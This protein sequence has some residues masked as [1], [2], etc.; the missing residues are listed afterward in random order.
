MIA[1][2]IY[3]LKRE[4][5][6]SD[7]FKGG[8]R[9]PWWAS[10]LSIYATLLSSITYMSIPAK[11]YATDWSYYPML[12]T[13]VVVTYPV[14][15]YYLPYF[16]KLNLT[17]AYEYLDQRFNYRVRFCASISF[18]SFMVARMALVLYM[19][20]LALATVSGMNIYITII[21]M[22]I[23]TL[24]YVTMG[25][26]EAVVWGDVIQGAILIGGVL[27]SA[28]YLIISTEGGF[29]QYISIGLAD[30]KFCL[31]EWSWDLTKPT[32]VVVIL[33]G[34]ANNLISLTSDQTVIQR[35][36]TTST[37][38]GAARSIILNSILSVF[39]SV[40]FYIIGTGLYTFYKTHPELY[41]STLSSTDAL[42]PYFMA[43]QMPVGVAGLV[44]A[45]IFSATMSTVSSNINSISASFTIDIYSHLYRK[46]SDK[47]RL[48]CARYT[49]IISGSLGVGLALLMATWDIKSLVDYFNSILGI[50]TSGLGALFFIGRFM[51]CID[52]RGALL[53]FFV[54]FIGVILISRYSTL[55]FLLYGAIGMI[56]SIATAFLY[57]LLAQKRIS[58]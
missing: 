8:G 27:F 19:P 14:I 13:I 40:F 39:V 38:Q 36:M 12:V 23:I 34:I 52:S 49:S 10:G 57:D 55:S 41:P 51:P 24:F 50:L 54:S 2:G 21:I 29:D 18:I 11:A 35:Y 56:L 37:Q 45:A 16:R 17:S 3:F 43:Y 30:N 58:I 47:K 6:S 7:F 5:S 20:A 1:V 46:L 42:L 32:F 26:I 4:Q 44:L 15:K 28:I 22:G 25:G 33:G 48:A 53:G 31:M 9:I